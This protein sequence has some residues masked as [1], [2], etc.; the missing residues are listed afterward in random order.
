MKEIEKLKS[1]SANPSAFRSNYEFNDLKVK[2]EYGDDFFFEII[3]ESN[4][5]EDKI[6]LLK[7]WMC[8]V[9]FDENMKTLIDGIKERIDHDMSSP[10]APTYKTEY[11]KTIFKDVMELYA[12]FSSLD[13]EFGGLNQKEFEDIFKS[14]SQYLLFKRTDRYSGQVL[15]NDM[16]NYSLNFLKLDPKENIQKISS[17]SK[18]NILALACKGAAL[19][20]LFLNHFV[21]NSYPRYFDTKEMERLLKKLN[22]GVEQDIKAKRG[23]PQKNNKTE[24]LEDIWNSDNRSF[25]SIL[26]ML[27]QPR[28]ILDNK[29]GFVKNVD[30]KNVWIPEPI[31][32]HVKY[33]QGFLFFCQNKGYVNL[34]GYSSREIQGV[35]ERT[36][37]LSVN[38]KSMIFKNILEIEEMYYRHFW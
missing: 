19:D 17:L 10:F 33:I 26:E 35:F 18:N 9:F 7:F 5:G 24:T 3:E 34:K 16:F 2:L 6:P 29:N 4:L 37:N 27:L 13:K 32:C 22:K 30:G 23:R 1:I 11:L 21:V 15:V 12:N 20:M 28:G 8:S 31:G 25:E 14:F 38:N 36:F